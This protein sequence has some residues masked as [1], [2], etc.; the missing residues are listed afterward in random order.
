MY[1]P[2]LRELEQLQ[3][4]LAKADPANETKAIDMVRQM[5]AVLRRRHDGRCLTV[6]AGL[7]DGPRRANRD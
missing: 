6:E 2:L 4:N 7:R 1:L 5:S 3:A